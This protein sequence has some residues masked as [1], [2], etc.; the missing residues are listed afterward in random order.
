MSTPT[1]RHGPITALDLRDQRFPN[2]PLGYD[3]G[4]VDRLLAELADELERL[5]KTSLQHEDR[6]R[7]L[8]AE[9]H[10]LRGRQ[11][12][13]GAQE[14]ATRLREQ[15]RVAREEALRQHAQELRGREESLR[16]H[17]EA[18]AEREESLRLHL[19]ALAERERGLRVR[20][21]ELAAR[22]EARAREPV[23]QA[24][25]PAA[26]M[27]PPLL[28]ADLR[29]E[30]EREAQLIIREARAAAERQ[31]HTA[32]AELRKLQ[33]EVPALWEARRVELAAFRQQLE[34]QLH[35]VAMAEQA[36]PPDLQRLVAR[37][38]ATGAP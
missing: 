28:R 32:Q 24:A 34:R 12:E 8:E 16:L 37:P 6:V 10:G 19:E 15:E 14:E 4:A 17:R 27:D 2:R 38:D 29:A 22:E 11:V 18:V 36:A 25:P 1:E 30:A 3:K 26:E 23:R 35:E 7:Q 5:T 33:T 20:E 31:V 21:E 13:W 9:L